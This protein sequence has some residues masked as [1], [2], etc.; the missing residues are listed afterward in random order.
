MSGIEAMSDGGTLSVRTMGQG[1]FAVIEIS[2]TGIGLSPEIKERI[3]EPFFTNKPSGTGLGLPLSA[4]IVTQH[5]GK[6]EVESDEGVGT[7]FRIVLPFQ[8]S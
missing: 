4:H 1:A 5:G 7:T 8:P 2:D 6:I 3:F